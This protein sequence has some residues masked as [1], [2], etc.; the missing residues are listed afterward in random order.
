M[1][2][3]CLPVNFRPS[4]SSSFEER[5]STDETSTDVE[6]AKEF[7]VTRHSLSPSRAFPAAERSAVE[8]LSSFARVQEREGGGPSKHVASRRTWTTQAGILTYHFCSIIEMT[9]YVR[10]GLFAGGHA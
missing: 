9:Y 5:S 4:F 1:L 2:I 8:T 6:P 3:P 7:P 10:L